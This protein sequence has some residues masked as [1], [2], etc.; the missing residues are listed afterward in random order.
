[1]R[2]LIVLNI[3]NCSE[4]PK[5]EAKRTPGAGYAEDYYCTAV[6]PK[7]KTSGYVEWARDVNPVPQWCPLLPSK[8]KVVPAPVEGM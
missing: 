8:L 2:T 1:M 7:K 3:E 6:S 4:C 5:N